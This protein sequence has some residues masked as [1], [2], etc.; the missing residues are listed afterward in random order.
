[1]EGN[2]LCP[3]HRIGSQIKT[4]LVSASLVVHIAEICFGLLT[5]TPVKCRNQAWQS[6][7]DLSGSPLAFQLP[8]MYP[9]LQRNHFLFQGKANT[10][11][12][13]EDRS[14][15]H[16]VFLFMYG[17]HNPSIIFCIGIPFRLHSVPFPLFFRTVLYFTRLLFICY[18][19][20]IT[21]HLQLSLP[22]LFI[23][24]SL[25]LPF[26][27]HGTFAL[28]IPLLPFIL[29]NMNSMGT[30]NNFP[31]SAIFSSPSANDL[32]PLALQTYFL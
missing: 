6:N 7:C 19:N 8:K 5:R 24:S 20:S 28:V 26:F 10:E 13:K 3:R 22:I 29:Y 14:W 30:V 17:F 16:A 27:F 11:K 32:Y 2:P 12:W 23:C 25:S 1:M 31:S 15:K 4:A 9:Y 21:G 18:I